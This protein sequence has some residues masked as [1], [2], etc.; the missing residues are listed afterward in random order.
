[1]SAET[2][3]Q[4]LLYRVPSCELTYET[5]GP[6]SSARLTSLS[7]PLLSLLCHL[8]IALIVSLSA[9][10]VPHPVAEPALRALVS[11]CYPTRLAIPLVLR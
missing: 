3:F 11:L 10:A 4:T 8:Q 9:P 7:P 1:M 5:P 2:P 6:Q